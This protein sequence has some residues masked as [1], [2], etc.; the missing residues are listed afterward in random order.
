V[1]GN[2]S[3]GGRGKSLDDLGVLEAGTSAAYTG[4]EQF[5]IRLCF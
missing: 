2:V 4:R 5:A 1:M 3:E